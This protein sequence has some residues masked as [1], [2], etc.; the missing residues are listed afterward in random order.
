[1]NGRKSAWGVCS[2]SKKREA[3]GGQ[4]QVNR[5]TGGKGC[6]G[7]GE[8]GVESEGRGW[9]G[10]ERETGEEGDVRRELRWR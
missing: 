6:G 9:D 8:G 10:D 1:M 7:E 2:Q 5:D 3:E 4:P